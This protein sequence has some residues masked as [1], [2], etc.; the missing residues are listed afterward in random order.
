MPRLAQPL[1]KAVVVTALVAGAFA[2]AAVHAP[3]AQAAIPCWKVLL[4]DWYDGRIDHV[5]PVRCYRD[6]LKHLPTDVSTYSR[7]HDDILRA[8]Q[9]AIAAQK[10][11]HK[12]VSANTPIPP[13]PESKGPNNGSGGAG[14]GAS[15]P[16]SSGSGE[17]GR[18]PGA[19][20]AS[21]V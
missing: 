3:R 15:G 5:Y 13:A 21:E 1:L 2:G 10:Q 9:S 20:L 14:T 18:D 6:A 19:G 11:Q 12:T 16:P 4:N 8:L 7:A 17:P